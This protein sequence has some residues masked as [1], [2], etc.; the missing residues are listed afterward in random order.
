MRTSFRAAGLA[1]AVLASTVLGAGAADAATGS[2]SHVPPR[3]ER[4]CLRIPNLTMRTEN[5]L[6]RIN[7]DAD[8]PGSLLW[9]DDRIADAE[10]IGR[11]G[12]VE[13]LTNRQ[14]VR[15]ASIEVFELR[16][17][18]LADLGERCEAAGIGR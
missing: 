10:E 4:A 2:S 7:G 5:V 13:F 17:V 3:V 16:L 15:E 9:L 12:W 14:A 1:T 6:A 8:A 18:T 11:E